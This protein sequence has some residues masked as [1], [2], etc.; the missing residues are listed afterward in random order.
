MAR[1]GKE[2]QYERKRKRLNITVSEEAHEFLQESVTNASRFIESLIMS[3]KNKI[4]PVIM[5][6][7]RIGD[8]PGGIRTHGHPV[9]S[10]AHHSGEEFEE[11]ESRTAI[12]EEK[13]SSGNIHGKD[14][15]GERFYVFNLNDIETFISESLSH[16]REKTTNENRTAVK[17]FLGFGEIIKKKT[18]GP[19][20]NAK[21]TELEA[22]ITFSSVRAYNNHMNTLKKSSYVGYV[23]S[24]LTFFGKKKGD[25][26]LQ[27]WAESIS[28]TLNEE[29]ALFAEE[30]EKASITWDEV[31]ADLI[32]YYSV[33]IDP[34]IPKSNQKKRA[35]AFRTMATLLF[36][37]TS[38]MRPEEMNRLD[39]NEINKE[40][41]SKGFFIIPAEK[42]KT[43]AKRAIPI[44]PAV[45]P[46]LE[47][48]TRLFDNKPFDIHNYRKYRARDGGTL[49]IGQAR[50]F[51]A[52]Y[53]RKYGIDEKIRIAIM[54]HDEGEILKEIRDEV[55]STVTDTHYRK[56]GV[57]E[58]V[59]HYQ[60]TVGAK[61]HPIPK[62][63]DLQK[64][65]R[66]LK[67]FMKN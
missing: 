10:R 38:G 39:W 23:R 61:F 34:A 27:D 41:L 54:G 45:M 22:K 52:K 59:K 4:Q 43:N 32:A 30:G 57:E 60:E 24:F 15:N 36:G 13:N 3:S 51:A 47:I 67:P 5:T 66:S 64:I 12:Q 37:I 49:N 53:W 42:T 33:V 9:M 18:N 40:S 17:Q 20:K 35:S 11:E 63:I 6:V 46:Y 8:G 1:K 19:H 50:N 16:A 25:R 14:T 28:Q 56:Y 65:E 7:S 29:K 62:G 44:H 55:K 2:T 31:A 26:T 21:I 58:I 48:L